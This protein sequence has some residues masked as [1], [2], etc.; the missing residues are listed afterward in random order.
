MEILHNARIIT[1]KPLAVIVCSPYMNTDSVIFTMEFTLEITEMASVERN[2]RY[3][4]A[5]VDVCLEQILLIVIVF[6]A[7]SVI[8]KMV[9]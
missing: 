6:T 5:H 3:G 7:A 9:I 8:C 2:P 4:I 1:N